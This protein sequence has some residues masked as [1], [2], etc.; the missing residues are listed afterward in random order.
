MTGCWTLLVLSLGV[1]LTGCAE[2]TVRQNGANVEGGFDYPTGGGGGTVDGG[3]GPSCVELD[4]DAS[5]ESVVDRLESQG[6][7]HGR[8]IAL[9]LFVRAGRLEAGMAQCP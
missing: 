3:M 2:H 7:G 5:F 4:K 9:G 1:C 6:F 8:A